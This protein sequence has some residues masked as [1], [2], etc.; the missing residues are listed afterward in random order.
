MNFQIIVCQC[1]CCSDCVPRV[2]FGIIYGCKREHLSGVVIRTLQASCLKPQTFRTHFRTL[3]TQKKK[4]FLNATTKSF[5]AKELCSGHKCARPWRAVFP[6][7]RAAV[8]RSWRLQ[9]GAL[10]LFCG[11][12]RPP[13]CE[14]ALLFVQQCK[15]RR[16]KN[17]AAWAFAKSA[18]LALDFYFCFI[19]WHE[20]GL[21]AQPFFLWGLV[22]RLRLVFTRTVLRTH[23]Q[24]V[25]ICC[26]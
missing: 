16:K 14:T 25:A 6:K 22:W 15:K 11:L 21:F 23:R 24:F 7:R 2:I 5:W 4:K 26:V 1:V 12:L 8:C 18:R 19:S 9:P 13:S 10:L 3:D 20:H 17:A